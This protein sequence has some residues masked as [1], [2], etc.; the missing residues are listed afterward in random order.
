MGMTPT[1]RLLTWLIRANAAVLLLAV[2]PV[3]F[4]PDLMADMHRRFDLGELARDWTRLGEQDP[5]WA[6]YVAPEARGGR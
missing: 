5:L 6:V 1:D 2:V 3:F 4:P